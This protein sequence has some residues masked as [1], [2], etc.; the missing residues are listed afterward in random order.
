MVIV[1]AGECGARAAF[2][3]REAGYA[4]PVTLIGDE[5]HLPYERP[6]LSKAV[7]TDRSAGAKLIADKARL[8]GAGIQH[9]RGASASAIDP[10]GHELA[11]AD[12]RTLRYDRLLLA[13]GA[14]PRRLP[15]AVPVAYLR[16]IDD[17]VAIRAR[18][19]P[20]KRLVVI[21]AGF[22]GLEL[23][24]S[25][26]VLGAAVT[27]VEAQPRILMRGVP[28]ELAAM[29][30]DRHVAG[31]VDLITATGVASI[32]GDIGSVSV[33]LASGGVMRADLVVAGIGAAPNIDLA[34]A[35]GLAIDNGVLVDEKLQTAE[36]DIF[37]AGDCCNALNPIFGRRVR[38]ESWRSAQEQGTLAARNM[39]GAEQALSAAPWFWSDQYELTLQVA[40]LAE[41]ATQTVR[42]RSAD[43]SLILFHLDG[44][45]RLLAASGLGVGNAVA[46]DI[47][48]AE[49]LIGRLATPDPAALAAPG[50]KLKG[51]L[52]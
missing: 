33:V 13:T 14:R 43:G 20:G 6:P 42:R 51:L 46:R 8:A 47:R 24:A 32:E 25:A 28:E 11:L 30:H 21:G 18:L 41:G 2:A 23:A 31:G 15:G 39:L 9:L 12:G 7:M 49:M 16:T 36:S 27:V 48:V 34:A 38:L 45:G 22:I 37:A 35:T 19:A 40:G 44:D 29:L 26:R 17:A 10:R 5:L 1:G 50:I 4:G 52:A 3:L